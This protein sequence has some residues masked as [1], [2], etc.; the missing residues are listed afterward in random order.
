MY[1]RVRR[2]I[3]AFLGSKSVS[4]G[5]LAQ[6]LKAVGRQPGDYSSRLN[7]HIRADMP[8]DA[9]LRGIH[10]S[11][12]RTIRVNEPGLRR[13]LDSEFLHDFRVAV[14]RTRSA[15]SQIK[16]VFPDEAIFRFREAFAWLGRVTG[17]TRDLDVYLLKIE[18]YQ[19]GISPSVREDLDP[20]LNFLHA[21]Q[22]DEHRHLVRVMDTDLYRDLIR[23]WRIFLNGAPGL[24]DMP[25]NARR[26]IRDVVSERI[27]RVYRR[28]YRNGGLVTPNTPAEGLHNL[29]KESKKLRYLIEILR[30][31]YPPDEIIRLTSPL[32]QLQDNLGAFNDY[33]VHQQAIKGF[34]DLMM[35]ENRYSAPTFMAMG[36]LVERLERGQKKERARFQPCFSE[37]A[38]KKNR[39]RFK[40]L[41]QPRI[42]KI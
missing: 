42:G 39:R 25:A 33:E 4:E 30:S 40:G 29:R 24:E 15:L 26:P 13:N 12:L 27:W 41:F 38:D 19:A 37:F 20:L 23:D 3:D 16:A 28:L 1:R 31:L 17:P 22:K 18:A 5:V 2:I 14:R 34:A 36:H 35:A 6:A 32:K 9:A 8:T 21:R 11:L 10:R 7:L